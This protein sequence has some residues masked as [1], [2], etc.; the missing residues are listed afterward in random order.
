MS[1]GEGL[2]GANVGALLDAAPDAIV[3]SDQDGRIRLVNRQAEALFG[4]DRAELIGEP[5]ELLVPQQTLARHP[6][7]RARYLHAAVARPM[8]AGQELSAR[9]KDGSEVPVEIALSSI[10]TDEGLLVSAAVRDVS[11]R[12]R[13]EAKYQGLLDAAPDAIVAVDEDGTI[14]LVNRQAEALFGYGREELLGGSLEL[15]IPERVK[16]VHPGHR[17]AYFAHPVTRPMG[18]GLELS[19]RRR[20]GTEFPVDISLSSVTTEEGR[21][22]TAAVRDVTDRQRAQVEQAELEDRLRRAEVE[23]ARA[24]MEAQLQQSQ[25]LESIG[26]LAGGIAHDFNNLLAGIMN[27]SELVLAGVSA[28][29][30]RHGDAQLDEVAADT[31]EIMAVAGR[32]ADLVRQL[33]I[34]SRREVTKPVVLDLNAVVTEMEKLL[35]RTIGEDI[36]LQTS[37][38]PGLAHTT[39]DKAQ[40]E[41]VLMNLAVNARDAMP[42][43][44]RLTLM[45]SE[46]EAD[47]DYASTHGI[48]PGPYVRLTVSDTGTGMPPDVAERAFEPFFTTKS[49]DRG[50]GLGLATVYGIVTQAGGDLTLYSEVGLGTT[51]R[52]NLPATVDR[53]EPG[54][55]ESA[56]PPPGGGETVLLV[57]DE[58]MVR[59]PARRMLV[60]RGYTVLAAADAAEALELAE[61]HHGTI[62]LLL[63]DVVMPGLS[64]KALAELLVEQRPDLQVLFMSGYSHDVIAHQG[65][66]EEGVMLVEK[67][68]VA[69]VLLA[70]IR[71]RLDGEVE[72]G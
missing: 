34:F 16:G 60:Q 48:A 3:V 20:D 25:R 1:G 21:L 19:A 40:F 36:H 8:G 18:A 45:T 47:E 68:F 38:R 70:A 22:V 9:R 66:L 41:Q 58:A 57:E 23:E 33:L 59:E 62:D 13:T 32:A 64:G 63:T 4:Y 15:L 50:S 24:Q 35:A 44:G 67:P 39:V 11:E 28:A 56:G 2:L 51:V 5:V 55:H 10:R 46:F 54:D 43:G 42:D 12:K 53:A 65:V 17:Q 7:L 71:E 30:D 37:L 52:V 29:R 49:R 6:Q 72:G 61:G 27:Y 26:Q 14:Q 31:R 69:E